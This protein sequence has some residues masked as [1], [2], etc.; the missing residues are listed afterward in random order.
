MALL[1]HDLIFAVENLFRNKYYLIS[2][3]WVSEALCSME[4]A[5]LRAER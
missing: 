1:K 2:T 4:I 3:N 5:P